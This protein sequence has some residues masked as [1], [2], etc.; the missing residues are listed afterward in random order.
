M[1]KNDDYIFEVVQHARRFGCLWCHRKRKFHFYVFMFF[2]G[3]T[4]IILQSSDLL[5]WF[6]YIQVMLDFQAA[7][8]HRLEEPAADIGLEPIC[9]MVCGVYNSNL[10]FLNFLHYITWGIIYFGWCQIN[11]NLRCHELSMDLSN[12]ILEALPQNYAEQVI[13]CNY[14]YFLF[15]RLLCYQKEIICTWFDV[16]DLLS[17]SWSTAPLHKTPLCCI[18]KKYNK[19]LFGIIHLCN[20]IVTAGQFWRYLQRFPRC[21]QGLSLSDCKFI[22]YFILSYDTWN[23]YFILGN[24]SFW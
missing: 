21:C 8:R 4:L 2:P 9:A 11:N 17:D 6:L 18:I 14:A 16:Y 20:G 1:G 3:G 5:L 22:P 23:W 19:K 7:E 15:R 12:N 10:G 24:I 13:I